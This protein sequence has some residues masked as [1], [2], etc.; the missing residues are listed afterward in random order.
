MAKRYGTVRVAPTLVPMKSD[1]LK[2]RKLTQNHI[3][4]ATKLV[5]NNKISQIFQQRNS[6]IE[7]GQPVR[8]PCTY[9]EWLEHHNILV[10]VES[11]C[12]QMRS[13]NEFV[14]DSCQF[15]RVLADVENCWHRS[16]WRCLVDVANLDRDYPGVW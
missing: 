13:R 11:L 4:I 7:R 8:S 1:L 9:V 14:G 15:A 12:R 10:E 16:I 3:E 5:I 2:L 6:S